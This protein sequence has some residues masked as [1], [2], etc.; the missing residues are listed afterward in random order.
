MW[1]TPPD[2]L[3][4]QPPNAARSR[5]TAALVS[6]GNT[7]DGHEQQSERFIVDR[8][9]DRADRKRHVLVDTHT[10]RTIKAY[11]SRPQAASD[12][13]F[14]NARRQ[15]TQRRARA[16]HMYRAPDGDPER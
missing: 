2:L 14:L 10:R 8:A 7:P 4:S 5:R 16:S 9:R 12:A 15:P 11:R 1:R 3:S 6:I 13:A